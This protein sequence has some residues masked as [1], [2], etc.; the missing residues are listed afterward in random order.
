[1]VNVISAMSATAIL[2]A[3]GCKFFSW[4]KTN[5]QYYLM[6]LFGLLG[7][8][9]I[10]ALVGDNINELLLT[11]TITVKSPEGAVSKA[12]FP[13]KQNKTYG[14]EIKLPDNK[15]R[16]NYIK[17]RPFSF[18]VY[19]MQFRHLLLPLTIPLGGLA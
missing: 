13:Y 6:L 14:G 1:M 7:V 17:N 5:Y 18:K 2:I 16:Q 8:G 9:M 10:I 4:Y 19:L 15:S 12:Y 3:I 11:K